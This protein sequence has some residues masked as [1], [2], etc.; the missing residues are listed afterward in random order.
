MEKPS[1]IIPRVIP[2]FFPFVSGPAKQALA[3]AKGLEERGISSP[4]LTTNPGVEQDVPD[5]G[6]IVKRFKSNTVAPNTRF[7]FS[8]IRYLEMVNPSIL[9][10]HYWRNPTSDSALLIARR[11]HIPFL[12]Q[13]HGVAFGY[14]YSIEPFALRIG[15]RLYDF[16]IRPIVMKSAAAVVASTK[17]EADELECYCFHRSKIKII[18][19]G[20]HRSFFIPGT[21][22][23]KADNSGLTLL[24]VGRL[25]PRRYIEQIIQA[26]AIIRC[27]G[28][29]VNLRIVGPEVI[30]AM[31]DGSGYVKRLKDLT[32]SLGMEKFVSFIGERRGSGLIEEYQSADVFLCSS[33]YENFGQPVAEAAAAGLPIVSTPIGAAVDILNDNKAGFLV[34]YKNPEAMAGSLARLCTDKPLRIHM[35][36]AAR[37]QAEDMFDWNKIVP[38]YIE[39][40]NSI[41][42][43]T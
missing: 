22:R 17:L 11:R 16:L 40:Y 39:L 35:G 4:V 31:G 27:Q 28:I 21:R 7:S 1:L 34:P 23:P 8:L 26:V 38:K 3:I 6:V 14:R 18:P 37:Q 30:L 32:N 13:S 5:K 36:L 12:V 19:V 25:A 41:I 10:I 15:R 42:A 2:E 33:L 20:V 29:D 43:A 9:H 24:T